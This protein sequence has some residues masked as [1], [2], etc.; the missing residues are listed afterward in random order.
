MS[1]FAF[2]CLYQ[3]LIF[4][5]KVTFRHLFSRPGPCDP[6][7]LVT[8]VHISNISTLI[9]PMLTKLFGPNILRALIF[10]INFLLGTKFFWPKYV[11]D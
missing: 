5:K 1:I 8:F 4:K 10:V 7:V 9:D 3:L 6:Y 2:I 11:L